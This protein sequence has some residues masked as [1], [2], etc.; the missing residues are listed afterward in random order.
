VPHIR[1]HRGHHARHDD[2]PVAI[3]RQ[4]AVVAP[5]ELFRRPT[6]HDARLGIG[7]VALRILRG[8]HKVTGKSDL[9]CLT[10]NLLKLLRARLVPAT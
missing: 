1:R 3:D 7:Q 9:I 4:L 10:H 2:L 5:H 8:V 6:F